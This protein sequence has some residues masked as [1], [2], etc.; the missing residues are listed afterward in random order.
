MTRYVA[1]NAA[2]VSKA[3]VSLLSE[4]NDIAASG[5][6]VSRSDV[7]N[8]TPSL[9]PWIGVYRALVQFEPRTLGAGSGAMVQ[10][11]DMVVVVQQSD[12]TSGEQCEDRLESLISSVCSVLLSDTSAKGTVHAM[13]EMSVSYED[14]KLAGD[15]FMQTAVIRATYETRVS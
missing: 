11:V 7:I 3:I 1:V 4:D 14:Y 2:S 9:C 15:N 8:E 12:G 5:A 13:R 6:S 10:L